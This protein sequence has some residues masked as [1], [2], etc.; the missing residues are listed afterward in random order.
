MNE[1]DRWDYILKLDEE[2]LLG[3]VILSEWCSF[4]VREADAA[5]VAGANL[6][7]ILTSVSGI[8]TYLRSE[9][10]Y[11]KGESLF[12]MIDT[13]PIDDTLRSGLHRL[14]MYRNQ[15]VHVA[16]PED[17]QDIQEHPEKYSAELQDM[18]RLAV[19]VLRQVIYENQCV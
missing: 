19:T 18:A 8:E 1:R 10:G 7:A 17:D 13:A 9:Y 15:W 14:R 5:F 6:A 4:I 3:G 12:R 16:D 2:L 11:G